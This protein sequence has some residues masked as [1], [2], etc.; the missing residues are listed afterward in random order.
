MNRAQAAT[1]CRWVGA[2][3]STEA[4]WEFA[5]RSTDGRTHPW[6]NEPPDATRENACGGE[7]AAAMSR[8]HIDAHAL[9]PGDDGFV[10]TAPVGSFPAGTSPDAAQAAAGFVAPD[11]Y[12]AIR[13]SNWIYVYDP[14]RT[15]AAHRL[16]DDPSVSSGEIGFRCARDG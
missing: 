8:M 4:E 10:Y 6:G 14:E 2:R 15:I 13:G 12:Y 9:Y 3:L 5:A 1:Y 16:C 7:C 11:L